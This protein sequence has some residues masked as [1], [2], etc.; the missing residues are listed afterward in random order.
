GMTV[1]VLGLVGSGGVMTARAFTIPD[2]VVYSEGVDAPQYVV[3]VEKSTQR[4]FLFSFH[5][6]S[7][8]K[9]KEWKCSTGENHGPKWEMGDK[10]TPEGIY[11]FVK[12]F[13]DEEL[14]PIYGIMAFPTDYPNVLDR[15]AGKNGSAI[16]LHGT[17]KVLRDNDS[18]GC[19]VLENENIQELSSYIDFYKTPIVIAQ[20][21]AE[22]PWSAVPAVDKPVRDLVRQWHEALVSRSYHDYLR[23]YDDRYL[24]DLRW[25]KGWRSTRQSAIRDLDDLRIDLSSLS[26][27]KY[28]TSYVALF[29]QLLA[30]GDSRVRIGRRKLFLE[31]AAGGLKIIGDVF[32]DDADRN[33]TET[34][35]RLAA[36]CRSIYDVAVTE[37]SVRKMLD[38]WLAAWSRMDMDAYGAFYGKGFVFNGMN[39]K[40]WL[41]YKRNLNFQ[42]DYIRVAMEDLKFLERSPETCVLT[43]VQ[44]YESDKYGDVGLKTLVLKKEDGQ[45]KIHRESWE[46]VNRPA[47]QETGA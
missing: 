4:L 9:E 38:G 28:G 25:W 40:A 22:A 27:V 12:K 14:A 35:D 31:E 2:L 18:S 29:D 6:N 47:T 20:T 30:S 24:P 26:V 19:V 37:K 21:V 23:F 17:N 45:W 11:F 10:K 41:A 5:K 46:K 34:G 36:A 39:R 3:L 15:E 43:F 7:V 1:L 32:Q 44:K 16:W 13:T 33:D 42:Y 8:R